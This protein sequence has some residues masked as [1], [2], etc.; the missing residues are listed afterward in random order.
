MKEKISIIYANRNKDIQRI[1]STLHSLEG[2]ETQNFEVVFVDYGS[3]PELV[4]NLEE[5]VSGYDFVRFFSLEVPQLLWNKSKALNYGIKK[6]IGSYL[7]IADVDL[8][9]H[10]GTTRFFEK[11]LDSEYFFLFELGYLT[12]TESHKLT[13]GYN[14]ENLS[15]TRFGRVNG[16]ILA[17]KGAFEKVNGLDEFFHF[18]GAEDEDLFARLEN[19]GYLRKEV[20]EPLFLHNWHQSFS[21]SEGK[22]L[23]ENP[24]VKNIMRI[25]QCHF[26][27][28]REKAIIRPLRQEKMGSIISKEEGE[29]LKKPTRRFKILNILAH[30]E[31]FL[32]EELVGLKGEIVEAEFKEDPYYHSLKHSLKKIFGKQTQPYCSLK[33]V[34]DI[35]LKRIVFN[36][37]NSNY[38]LTIADDKKS[39]I[40]RIQL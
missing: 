15:A 2:Q 28:N 8:I 23:T 21:G 17:P 32:H 10:P 5:L 35:L 20:S 34:N 31:H 38:S 16:M 7:F 11:K 3:D 25:N 13:E 18:Y 33:E 1:K 12:K 27:E 14:F 19:A 22:I 6:A 36:Y 29:L 24:R 37:R 26:M 4:H 40:F 9:F 30:V 39:I